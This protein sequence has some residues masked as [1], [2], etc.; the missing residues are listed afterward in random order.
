MLVNCCTSA[1][2][3]FLTE[4]PLDQELHTLEISESDIDQ[5]QKILP[6]TIDF[7]HQMHMDQKQQK[8]QYTMEKQLA[9]Y[10]ERI[11][12]WKASKEEQ[13][14]LEFGEKTD[15]SFIR[16]RQK[17]K[18]YQVKT[19]SNNSSQYFKDLTSL[20][21]DPYLKVIAVFYNN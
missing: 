17:E 8:V 9:V 21:G 10:E 12:N 15:L 2:E 18:E 14:E 20:N 4:Y 11:K 13:M 6:Q 3:V 16:K 19:I 1:F 7:A 5:L